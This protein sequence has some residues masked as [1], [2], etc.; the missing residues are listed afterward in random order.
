MA[1]TVKFEGGRELARALEEL[2]KATARNVLNRVLTKAAANMDDIASSF[3]PV[4][5]GALQRSVVTGKKLTRAQQRQQ[6]R[7]GKHF[8]EVHVGTNNPAG[9]FQE[10]GTFKE[11]AQ[12]FMRPTWESTKDGMLKTIKTELGTEIEKARARLAKKAAKFG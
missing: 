4:E 2:P 11:P 5:T 12:P 1:V 3:A 8:A 10:F 9:I 7:D 6:K